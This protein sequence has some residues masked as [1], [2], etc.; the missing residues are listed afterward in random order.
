MKHADANF[1]EKHVIEAILIYFFIHYHS[2]VRNITMNSVKSGYQV[3]WCRHLP[4]YTVNALLGIKLCLFVWKKE[5]DKERKR[6]SSLE[7]GVLEV[8]EFRRDKSIC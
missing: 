2:H 7:R 6:L 5:E 4:F 3:K 8:G 1:Y